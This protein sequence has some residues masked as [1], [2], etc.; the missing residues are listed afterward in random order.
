MILVFLSF[1][2]AAAC[3][4]RLHACIAGQLLH[5]TLGADAFNLQIGIILCSAVS[6]SHVGR[7][8][9][10]AP[11][12]FYSLIGRLVLAVLCSLC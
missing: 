11:A 7:V 9:T 5:T 6:P 3:H 12:R 4:K 2:R 1:H 10:G 8:R